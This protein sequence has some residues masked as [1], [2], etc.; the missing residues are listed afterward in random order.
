MTVTKP[1]FWDKKIGLFSILL[2]PFSILFLFLIFLRKKFTKEN[3]FK[4]PIICV[5]NIYIGGTGKTPASLFL[6]NELSKLGRNPAILRKYYRN[7]FD[8]YNLIKRSFKNLIINKNRF[9]GLKEA[10]KS[11]KDVVILDDGFQDYTIKK[12]LKII[13]FHQNQLIG[14]GLVLPSGPLRE[15]LNTLKDVQIVLINGNKNNFFEEKILNI[16]D[17]LKIFYSSYKAINAEEFRSKKLFALAG[18]G[19]PENFFKLVE[20]NNLKIEKKLIFPDH[21]MFSKDEILNVIN[22]AEKNNCQI[23][24]TEKDYYKIKDFNIDKIK[25]LKV[26]LKIKDYENFI[27]LVKNI[28]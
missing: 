3:A 22:Q 14:N 24:M 12:D 15:S 21:Y 4:I 8:E 27:T 23:I 25:Y 26:V 6:A 11:G 10:E 13:C 28:L 19:N 17:K 9:D 16:N 2:L 20:D 7:H 1:R 18:I 5:G